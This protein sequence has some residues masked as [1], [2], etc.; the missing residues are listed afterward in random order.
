MNNN[1]RDFREPNNI[2][3]AEIKDWKHVFEEKINCNKD[4]LNC[5]KNLLPSLP[6]NLGDT[7]CWKNN[8]PSVP[9][10]GID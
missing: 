1:K 8:Y 7:K 2:E 6:C 4:D 5:W 9:C 3:S 10:S